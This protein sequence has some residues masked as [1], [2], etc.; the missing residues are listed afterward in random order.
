MDW[1]EVPQVIA[2]FQRRTIELLA[3]KYR[4][5]I[6]ISETVTDYEYDMLEREWKNLGIRL[7]YD[8][9]AHPHWIGFDERHPLATL[10]RESVE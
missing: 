5:Y 10:A 4:Y 6:L 7:G 9:D 2:E 3:H 1:A 8:M